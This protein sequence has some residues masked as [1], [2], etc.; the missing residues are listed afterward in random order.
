MN[1]DTL[2]NWGLNG[3]AFILIAIGVL[4]LVVGLRKIVFVPEVIQNSPSSQTQ[5][6]FSQRRAGIS[7]CLIAG[8]CGCIAIALFFKGFSRD[9]LIFKCS[10]TF[11][12]C[13]FIGTSFFLNIKSR[14]NLY[15]HQMGRG[16]SRWYLAGA[17]ICLFLG[18]ITFLLLE[19]SL[20]FILLGIEL[21][22][23]LI[24]ISL[25][26]MFRRVHSIE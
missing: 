15:Q 2:L 13:L 20:S 10:L 7:L 17:G 8:A 1:T 19:S 14:T 24:F 5:S 6:L 18:P 25:F 26:I 12:A 9:I 4:A 3:I 23:A 21:V 16:E 22:G 11:I